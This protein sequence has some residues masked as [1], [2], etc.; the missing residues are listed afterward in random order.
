[1]SLKTIT[2]FNYL[3]ESFFSIF[4]E[5]RKIFN[6][7]FH[8]YFLY[9]SLL[10]VFFKNFE[11]SILKYSFQ[12]KVNDLNQTTPLFSLKLN[13]SKR[14]LFATQLDYKLTCLQNYSCGVIL[15]KLKIIDKKYLKKSREF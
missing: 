7:F 1:M 15:K 4:Y 6:V 11:G 12:T 9:I 10:K 3:Y 13:I 8:K 5:R 2:R 14:Q